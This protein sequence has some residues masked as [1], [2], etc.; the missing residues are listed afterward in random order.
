MAFQLA[1][2]PSPSRNNEKPTDLIEEV[3]EQ[4]TWTDLQ[5]ASKDGNLALVSQLLARGDDVNAPAKGYY[6][7]TAL[8]AACLFG[9]EDIVRKLIEY[10]ADVNASGGNNGSLNALSQ[11]CVKGN[12][13]V[14]ELLVESGAEINAPVKRYHGRTALQAAA[15]AGQLA[16]VRYL[17]DAGAE[18]NAPAAATGG[19]TALAAAASG[20][21]ASEEH[22]QIVKLLVEKG[23]NVDA[24]PSKSK[25]L[26][27]GPA[28][29][30]EHRILTQHTGKGL[31]ALQAASLNGNLDIVYILISAGANVNAP[32]SSFKGGTALHAATEKGHIE[33]VR[34]LLEAG[35]DVEAQSGW[36]KQTPLQSAA[37]RGQEEIARLLIA[38][39]KQLPDPSYIT[40]GG[41]IL[42]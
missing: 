8:Q 30:P 41:Q 29:H 27:Q 4:D 9:H 16:V 12:L 23:A 35:A 31:T 6:G 5:V 32:G 24:P 21:P 13:A 3:D 1:S 2:I 18:I 39:L 20:D 28:L 10:G 15:E 33:I 7:N 34:R 14:V 36:G 37:V 22:M 17:L 38:R 26:V 11:A 19:L 25:S 42:F 40:S